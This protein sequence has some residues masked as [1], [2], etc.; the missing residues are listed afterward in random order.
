MKFLTSI[1]LHSQKEFLIDYHSNILLLGSCFAESIGD[2][3]NYFEFQKTQNPFGI[4]FHPVAIQSLIEKAVTKYIYTEKDIFFHNE[5]WHCFEA[6]SKLSKLNKKELLQ[7]LNEQVAITKKAL[8]EASHV[9][10][11][12]GTA[13]VYT[14]K[15]TL[16]TVSNCHKLP[17]NQFAKSLL[18]IDKISQTLETLVTDIKQANPQ[19][20]IIFTISPV[21]HLKDG[22]VE[23]T[24]SKAHLIGALHQVVSSKQN[25]YYFPAYEL[26]IDELRDYRFY[27]P[28]MIHPN[29]TAVNYIW[30]KF[31][32]VWLSDKASTTMQAVD[33]IKK[34]MLHKPFNPKSKAHKLFLEKLKSKKK[35]LQKTFPNMEF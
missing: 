26:M 30:E 1:P 20:S 14:F 16:K 23:N 32:S 17:S 18:S 5:Q 28:D 15:N 13:W 12:L 24:Q 3:I 9:V 27:K 35:A 6:H 11:T 25:T 10:I 29:Q 22:F 34:G 19:A 4:L 33:E 2:K 31:C 7:H 8:F 21:R